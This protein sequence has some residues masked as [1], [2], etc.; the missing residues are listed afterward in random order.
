MDGTSLAKKCIFSFRTLPMLKR[1]LPFILICLFISSL[2]A[3]VHAQTQDDFNT[4]LG[5][6][7]T[8]AADAK[9]AMTIAKGLYQMVERNKTLQTYSN[10]YLLKTIFEN[11]APDQKLAKECEEKATKAMN[12]LVGVSTEN[13]VDTTNPTN[14]WYYVIYPALF[15]T[16]DPQNARRAVE[17]LKKNP[18]LE[19]FNS[20]TFIAYAFERN[21]DFSDAK[22]NYEKALTVCKGRKSG[23]SPICIL[24]QFPRSHRRIPESR[25]IHS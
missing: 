18:D 12:A 15:K 5:E 7:Y 21:G 13:N 20:Y 24:Y 6:I 19:N 2:P 25:R 3:I 9:K 4:R 1:L 14:Q 17:F 8:N 22:V 16:K 11:Q 10:Y 23:I